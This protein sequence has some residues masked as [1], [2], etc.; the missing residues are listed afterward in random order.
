MTRWV[1][2]HWGDDIDT[3]SFS[4]GSYGFFDITND[5]GGMGEGLTATRRRKTDPYKM[6]KELAN[7]YM[8]NGMLYHDSSTWDYSELTEKFLKD[9]D[10]VQFIENHPRRGL[11]K[12]RLYIK[13]LTIL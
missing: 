5:N 4:G 13:L 3:I 10:N 11:P 9:A 1:E 8:S 7:L 6:L 2:E 12:E